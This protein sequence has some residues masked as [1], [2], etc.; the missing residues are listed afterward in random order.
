MDSHATVALVVAF[1]IKDREGAQFG[2]DGSVRNFTV[3]EGPQPSL[4]GNK[5][6]VDGEF[7][8]IFSYL[9]YGRKVK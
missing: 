4:K 7:K 5:C 8:N 1:S 6:F 9:Y 2:M 3:K